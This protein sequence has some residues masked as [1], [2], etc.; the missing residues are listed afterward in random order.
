[1][2][3]GISL[4]K[5][6]DLYGYSVSLKHENDVSRHRSYFGATISVLM[7][8]LI[9]TQFSYAVERLNNPKYAQLLQ[10]TSYNKLDELG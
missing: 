3:F 1:M 9:L 6:F 8:T 10:H 5:T 4:L 2:V 7:L